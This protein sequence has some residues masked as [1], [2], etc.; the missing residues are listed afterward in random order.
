MEA[1]PPQIFA[2]RLQECLEFERAMKLSQLSL[3]QIHAAISMADNIATAHSLG[4][5][6]VQ[7]VTASRGDAD[8]PALQRAGQDLQK[9][10]EPLRQ[11]HQSIIDSM[12]SITRSRQRAPD[13]QIDED[14]R[15]VDLR[16]ELEHRLHKEEANGASDSSV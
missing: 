4:T 1:D 12:D 3:N 5:I 10:L 2:L 14:K 15:L 8:D 6:V 9:I 16:R 11:L 7:M 13:D